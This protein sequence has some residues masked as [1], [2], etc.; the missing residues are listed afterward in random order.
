MDPRALLE[1]LECKNLPGLYLAGQVNGT[2]GYEEAAAL[3]FWAGL[4]AAR[5][6]RREPPFLPRPG[7]NLP[8]GPGGRPG[9]ARRDRTLPDVHRPSRIP[10]P[11]RPAKRIPQADA[12]GGA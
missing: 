7:G 1:T 6:L 4:N 9:D 10:P 11:S 2:T 5:A 12:I 8:R 3:G